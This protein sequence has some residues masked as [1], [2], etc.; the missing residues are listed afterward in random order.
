MERSLE[1]TFVLIMKIYSCTPVSFIG[2][3][4]YFSRE[5]G[6]YSRGLAKLGIES[7][8]VMANPAYAVD[9]PELLRTDYPNLESSEWWKSQNLDGVILYSWAAPRFNRVAEALNDAGIPFLVQM[10]TCGI[11]S[12]ESNPMEWFWS[13]WTRSLH[14]RSWL[15]GKSVDL[16]KHLLEGILSITARNRI[17]HYCYATAITVPTPL[18]TLWVRREA[19][20]FGGSELSS[21]FHYLPHPQDERF[22]YSGVKKE[23][24]V[25]SIGRWGK[26]AWAQKNPRALIEAYRLFLQ[27]KPAWRGVII[28][29][30]ATELLRGLGVKPVERLSFVEQ[31]NHEELTD[32]LNLASVAFWSSR[33]EGQQ[34]TGAQALCCGCSVVSHGSPLMSCFHHY[35]SKSSGRLAM[36]NNVAGLADALELES[37]SWECGLRDPVKISSVWIPEFHA[38]SVARRALHL[39]GLSNDW[40]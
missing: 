3:E 31:V 25:V 30:G 18:G 32:Y 39:L 13:S 16:L 15:E 7:R 21:K 26:E 17:H 33:W 8:A 20:F 34:G 24:L 9:F 37:K 6:M 27:R 22:A 5:S 23:Q 29:A 38:T 28:G 19:E 11:V 1:I 36:R 35:V 10:D 40:K 4:S 14:E 2:D 12:R